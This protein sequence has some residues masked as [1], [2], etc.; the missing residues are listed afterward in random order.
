[1]IIKETFYQKNG[2]RA[3]KKELKTNLKI[4]F[5]VL[6]NKSLFKELCI[7]IKRK[8]TFMWILILKLT[9]SLM[10]RKKISVP[11]TE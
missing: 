2:D 4:E 11:I 3:N 1:M 7:S 9:L 6:F 8:K 10:I 5:I